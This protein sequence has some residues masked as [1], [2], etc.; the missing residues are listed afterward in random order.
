MMVLCYTARLRFAK[1]VS[2]EGPATD[3]FL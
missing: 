2:E 1:V 3:F